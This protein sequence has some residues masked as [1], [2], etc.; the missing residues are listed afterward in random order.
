ME[1]PPTISLSLIH[2]HQWEFPPLHLVFTFSSPTWV[3]QMNGH[4]A[5]KVHKYS[6]YFYFPR[7]NSSWVERLQFV[8]RNL[9]CLRA[10]VFD[11]LEP[12][13]VS[14]PS[15]SITVVT[16]W[17]P[18][19]QRQAAGWKDN[20]T[21]NMEWARET[22]EGFRPLKKAKHTYLWLTCFLPFHQ[23]VSIVVLNSEICPY[24]PAMLQNIQK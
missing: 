3:F 4:V 23:L 21:G 13:E 8:P 24:R 5:G 19:I 2:P 1:Y 6:Q 10:G 7:R 9:S 14:T 17:K 20:Y 22:D 18:Y 11:V 12:G 16:F 15:I